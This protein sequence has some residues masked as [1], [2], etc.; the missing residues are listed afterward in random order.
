MQKSENILTQKYKR[1]LNSGKG[2]R[3]VVIL[4]PEQL[5]KFIDT[6]LQFRG[7]YISD[8]NEDVFAVPRSKIKWGQGDVAIRNLTK[9][10]D[11]QRPDAI[12]SNKLR[13]HIATVTQILSLSKEKSKQFSKFMGHT[14]KTHAE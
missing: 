1:V 5:Q 8:K 2:S 13:K 7:K 3:A 10:F 4:I 12:T 11:L 6:L 9:K 14:E